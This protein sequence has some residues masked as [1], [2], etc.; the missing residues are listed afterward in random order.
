MLADTSGGAQQGRLQA[1]CGRP[2]AARATDFNAV[3]LASAL[4]KPLALR[5]PCAGMTA[6]ATPTPT[7]FPTVSSP[8]DQALRRFKAE[9]SDND[10]STFSL[11]T[12]EDLKKEILKLQEKQASEKRIQNLNRLTAFVEAMDQFDKVIQ[13]FLNASDYLGFVWVSFELSQLCPGLTLLSGTGEIHTG[14]RRTWGDALHREVLTPAQVASSHAEALNILLEAYQEIGEHIP[15]LAQYESLPVSNVYL[16]QVLGF[17][18][19]DILEFHLK[20]VKHFRQK[21][22]PRA[23]QALD[24]C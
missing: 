1:D 9:L 20:A 11:T 19:T 5:R 16:Q 21:G 6:M 10:I 7:S 4:E 14:G 23:A 3:A 15:L 17:I 18:Y 24:Q 12:A 2:H 13:V 8:F 22:L